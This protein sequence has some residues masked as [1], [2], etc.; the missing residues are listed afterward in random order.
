MASVIHVVCRTLEVT[1]VT[2]IVGG[3]VA[4]IEVV[5]EINIVDIGRRDIATRC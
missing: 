5:T 4:L 2:V 1:R 3:F